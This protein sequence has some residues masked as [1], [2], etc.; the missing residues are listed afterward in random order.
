ME[1]GQPKLSERIV[2]KLVCSKQG[3]MMLGPLAHGRLYMT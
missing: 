3:P 1:I 2:K